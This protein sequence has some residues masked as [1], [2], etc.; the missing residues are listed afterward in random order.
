MSELKGE[1]R[2]EEL[3]IVSGGDGTMKVGEPISGSGSAGDGP[4][5]AKDPT[6]AIVTTFNILGILA[7]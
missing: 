5:G 1:L 2:I 4:P 3:E 6:S 7:L